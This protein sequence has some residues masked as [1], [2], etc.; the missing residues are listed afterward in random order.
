MIEQMTDGLSQG[1]LLEGVLGGEPMLKYVPLH[2]SAA[3]RS[4]KLI[5]WVK[6]WLGKDSVLLKREEWFTLRNDIQGGS[7]SEDFLW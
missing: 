2:L 4:E 3:H 1:D 7:V 6:S 5:H